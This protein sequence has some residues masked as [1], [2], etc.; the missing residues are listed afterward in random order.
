M[1]VNAVRTPVGR[2]GGAYKDEQVAEI[3]AKT[4][5]PAGEGVPVQHDAEA[6]EGTEGRGP[7]EGDEL[8]YSARTHREQVNSCCTSTRASPIGG[9]FC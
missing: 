6:A 4:F 2:R 8:K 5:A 3:L 7:A 9:R 1:I